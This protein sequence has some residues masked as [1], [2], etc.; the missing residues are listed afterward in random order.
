MVKR[1]SIVPGISRVSVASGYGDSRVIDSNRR[2]RVGP[3]ALDPDAEAAIQA[4]ERRA[5][6][7][8]GRPECIERLERLA[9]ALRGGARRVV[10]T[11]YRPEQTAAA[12]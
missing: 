11:S 7:G 12:A 8:A 4:S 2:R 5:I 9:H 3:A 6:V 1:I 10:Q